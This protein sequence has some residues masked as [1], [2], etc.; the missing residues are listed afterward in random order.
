MNEQ[1]EYPLVSAIALAGREQL[2]DL[3][4]CITCFKA[5]TYPYK[6]GANVQDQYRP[7]QD[8]LT[9]GNNRSIRCK[10]CPSPKVCSIY[11]YL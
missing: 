7:L 5:Q 4:Q 10:M 6:V 1:T 3:I 9:Q 8:I 2:P 11:G